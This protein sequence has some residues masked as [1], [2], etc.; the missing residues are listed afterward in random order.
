MLQEQMLDVG[1]RFLSLRLSSF[2]F[3]DGKSMDRACGYAD[4]TVSAGFF[5]N[6]Y[7]WWF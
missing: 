7:N 6:R 1:L 5:F 3:H 4:L 2:Y